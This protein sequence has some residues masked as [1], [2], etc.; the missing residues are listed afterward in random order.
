MQIAWLRENNYV[1]A[2]K[3]DDQIE[4]DQQNSLLQIKF[5]LFDRKW[6][7]SVDLKESLLVILDISG[8]RQ[9]KER[10]ST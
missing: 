6:F 4:Q 2:V 9:I 1:Y 8:F 10:K 5:S 3:N 7:L